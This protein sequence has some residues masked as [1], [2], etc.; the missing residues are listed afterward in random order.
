[1]KWG[2]DFDVLHLLVH[3]SAIAVTAGYSYDTFAYEICFY[4]IYICGIY[5]YKAL[6][7]L[8][9]DWTVVMK[10]QV[11]IKEKCK[12][13]IK[14]FSMIIYRYN[15]YFVK[16]LPFMVLEL[17]FTKSEYLERNFLN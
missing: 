12:M 13:W 7:F 11:Y 14:E 10:M 16:N 8:S 4:G 6:K 5:I 3:K 15:E 1:V 17:I 2:N 9:I